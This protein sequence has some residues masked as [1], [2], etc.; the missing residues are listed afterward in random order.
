M[1]M[2]WVTESPAREHRADENFMLKLIKVQ[3]R[4]DRIAQSDFA[5][6][7]R[8]ATTNGRLQH[9]GLLWYLYALYYILISSCKTLTV[10]LDCVTSR[11][12]LP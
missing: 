2:A 1:V 7:A 8:L 9:V 4:L 6:V 12:E 10:S 5:G 11:I 3:S